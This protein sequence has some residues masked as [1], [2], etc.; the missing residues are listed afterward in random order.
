[1]D[2]R[3]KL[4]DEENLLKRQTFYLHPQRYDELFVKPDEREAEPLSVGGRSVEEVVDDIDA[5]DA[6]FDALEAKRE[7]SGADLHYID[8]SEGAWV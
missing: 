7:V 8:R 4:Q 2:R 6:Y 1:M 3:R 5:L